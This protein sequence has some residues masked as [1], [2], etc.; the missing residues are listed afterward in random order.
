MEIIDFATIPSTMTLVKLD[1]ITH[2]ESQELSEKLPNLLESNQSAQKPE[3]DHSSEE[4][5]NEEQE[6]Y[7]KEV[8]PQIEF[9]D[10]E[11]PLY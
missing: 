2:E 1:A 4:N 7:I 3:G 10:P 8:L 11:Y 5:P 6:K 9:S